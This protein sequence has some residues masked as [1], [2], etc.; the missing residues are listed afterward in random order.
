MYIYD[1]FICLFIVIVSQ[2]NC[3]ADTRVDR[4]ELDCMAAYLKQHEFPQKSLNRTGETRASEVL[5]YAQIELLRETFLTELDKELQADEEL[6]PHASCLVEKANTSAMFELSMK[7]ILIQDTKKMSK[8]KM[9]KALKAIEYAMEKKLEIAVALC[10]ADK[11]FGEMF[12]EAYAIAYAEVNTSNFTEEDLKFTYC[13]KKY[14]VDNNLFNHSYQVNLNSKN[15]NVSYL[16]CDEIVQNL[17]REAVDELKEAFE[18]ESERVSKRKMKCISN[19]I[20]NSWYYETLFNV[21]ILAEIGL[22]EKD[23]ANE[24]IKFIRSMENIYENVMKCSTF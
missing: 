7:Q 21:I 14:M 13:S 11:V 18:E 1:R 10:T 22:S 8:R 12:D 15:V 6:A 5:C 20:R 19:A 9:K 2:V 24:R 17:I 3:D 4:K 16:N 23:K